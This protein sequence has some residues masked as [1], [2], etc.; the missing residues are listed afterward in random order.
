MIGKGYVSAFVL[1]ENSFWEQPTFKIERDATEREIER[2][3]RWSLR[4]R[5]IVLVCGIAEDPDAG[6]IPLEDQD[7]ETLEVFGD[8]ETSCWCG[9]CGSPNV[10]LL[11]WIDPN[12]EEIV[13]GNDC[14]GQSDIFCATCDEEGRC[15]NPSRLAFDS[16][17][18]DRLR[19]NKQ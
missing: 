9:A 5:D 3:I 7:I 4:T 19:R 12:T 17:E 8:I 10:Q 2:A 14:P 6:E 13:G 15:P 11:D 16:E 18:A 1:F